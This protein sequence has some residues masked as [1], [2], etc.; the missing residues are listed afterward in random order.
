M[1]IHILY[2]TFI[3]VILLVKSVQH[4]TRGSRREHVEVDV[5]TLTKWCQCGYG[6][7]TVGM[8]HALKVHYC[9]YGC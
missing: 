9:A 5:Y 3:V 7:L 2:E 6:P 8:I 1:L 4:R